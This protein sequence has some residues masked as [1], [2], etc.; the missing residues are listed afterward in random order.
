MPSK[1][2]N[3]RDK[4]E[5][6]Q[7]DLSLMQLTE[8]PVKEISELPKGTH[9]DLSNN[10]LTWLPENFPTMTH[11]IHL[12]LS[13]NQLSDLPEYFGQLKNL[14]HLDLYSNQLT[15]LPPS[16]SQLKSL[17]WLDL[18]NNPLRGNLSKAAGPCI[19]PSDCA[20]CAKQVV[21]LMKNIQST[22]DRERQKQLMHERKLEE[23]RKLAAELERE[24]IRAAKKLAK[25]KRR[26]EAREREE[27]AR[28][29]E[30]I[31][32]MNSIRHEME[33]NHR[34]NSAKI[35]GNGKLDKSA[36]SSQSAASS[37][38]WTVWILFVT[39][40]FL[41]IGFGASL[42]WIYTGGHLDQS[43]IERALPLIQRDVDAKLAEL[44]LKTSQLIE[45]TRPYTKK[46]QENANWLWEDFQR[47]NDIVAHKINVHLGP[48]FCSSKK[49]LV[50]YWNV[51]QTQAGRAWISAKPYWNQFLSVMASYVKLAYAWLETNL[52]I[53]VDFLYHR[54]V[55]MVDVIQSFVN[56]LIK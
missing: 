9:L 17:K 23:E 39:M 53:Y 12:D 45:Q 50:Q 1:T 52:P 8:V 56:N 41:S 2:N 49:A 38:L 54:S 13:K 14:R 31:A 20:T 48:Y 40:F 26:L 29:E 10:L 34:G 51:A 55:E 28:R 7:L 27:A 36:A 11:L 18:K 43:S 16:F 47:R 22:Q 30:E 15:K 46:F 21:A 32:A 5:D 6:N 37:C 4:L 44:S 33:Q 35:N 19:T 24:K 42:I 25:E 3:L